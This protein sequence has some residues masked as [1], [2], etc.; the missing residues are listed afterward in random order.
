VIPYE[1]EGNN[2]QVGGY[3]NHTFAITTNSPDNSR[4]MG[5]VAVLRAVKSRIVVFIKI[6]TA[7]IINVPVPVI[8]NSVYGLV[9]VDPDIG[10]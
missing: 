5:A 7:N 10:C 2:S 4:Y 8:I 3:S 9:G 1:F 6:P